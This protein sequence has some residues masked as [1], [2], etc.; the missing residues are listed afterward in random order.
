MLLE[1]VHFYVA[2]IRRIRRNIYNNHFGFPLKTSDHI[3]IVTRQDSEDDASIDS[4][5]VN[6]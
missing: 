3:Y 1:I 6:I 2:N 4:G 5:G